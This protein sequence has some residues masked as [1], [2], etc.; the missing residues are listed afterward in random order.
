M[1]IKQHPVLYLLALQTAGKDKTKCM[2]N[3]IQNSRDSL[4][5]EKSDS[6]LTSHSLYNFFFLLPD[7]L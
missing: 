3:T 6:S 4:Y 1:G 5:R 7:T 2:L